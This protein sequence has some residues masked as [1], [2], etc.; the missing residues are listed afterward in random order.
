MSFHMMRMRT[1]TNEIMLKRPIVNC[2]RLRTQRP[3]T[4][5]AEIIALGLSAYASALPLPRGGTD[6]TGPATRSGL[7]LWRYAYARLECLR[8]GPPATAWRY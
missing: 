1:S 3:I 4:Q 8:V 5:H 7:H 6:L 2:Q